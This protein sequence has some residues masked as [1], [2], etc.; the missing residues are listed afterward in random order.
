MT[1][2]SLGV[3]EQRPVKVRLSE[4]RWVDGWLEAISR[5]EGAWCWH[6]RYSPTPAQTCLG[7]FE[8]DHIRGT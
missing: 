2:V 1:Y 3:N 4:E 6:V 8:E 7:C 5:A